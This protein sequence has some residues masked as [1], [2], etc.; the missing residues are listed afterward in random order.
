MTKFYFLR[1][2]KTVYNQQ[3]RIQGGAV[4]SPLLP[5]AIE[6]TEK[7]GRFLTDVDFD[8][9]V[10]RPQKRALST[11]K[12]AI[13]QLKKQP[14]R[15][16]A[17]DLREMG[18]GD[19]DGD[20]VADHIHDPEMI[21]IYKDPENYTGDKFNG[22]SYYEVMERGKNYLRTV[23][24]RFPKG[25]ILVVAHSLTISSVI[26]ALLG[27]DFDTM[28]KRGMVDNTSVSIVETPDFKD[29]SLKMWNNTDFLKK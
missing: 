12:H 24:E 5:E 19:W 2:G 13:S 22:E 28:L 21:K 26:G 4:D 6:N 15:E 3:D 8:L 20:L 7:A 17:G 11:A 25:N 27:D 29:F 18:F 16:I 1:H 23:F 14:P 9:A 10:S